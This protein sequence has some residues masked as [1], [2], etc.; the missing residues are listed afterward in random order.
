[1][2]GQRRVDRRAWMRGVG[3]WIGM[4]IAAAA[5]RAARADASAAGAA[6][7]ALL[8]AADEEDL[9]LVPQNALGRGDLRHAG[10]FGDLITDGWREAVAAASRRQRARLDRIDRASLGDAD[11]IARDVFAWQLDTTLRAH[12]DGVA[13][14]QQQMP[15]DHLFGP[16]VVFAQLSAG[17]GVAP[18]ETVAHFEQGLQRLGGYAVWLDRAI[19]QMR[20]GITQGH[21][22]PAIVTERLIAQ[23]R[24]TLEAGV[25]GSPF[26]RPLAR[27]HGRAGRDVQARLASR[28]EAV[29]RRRI[30]PASARMLEFLEREYL[31]ARGDGPPGLAGMRDGALVYRHALQTH[32][33]LALS[34]EQI[35]RL[36]LDEVARIEGERDAL[37][38]RLGFAGS[39]AA[40]S[41]RV[42][43]DPALAYA[44]AD[45]LLQRHRDAVA[46]I[47][48][49]LPRWF[50]RLPRAPLDVRLVPPEQQETAGGAYYVIGTADG[51]RPGVFYVNPHDLPNQVACRVLALTLHEAVPGHHLQG[52][53][54]LEDPTLPALLRHGY[55]TAYGEG[56]ALYAESLGHEMGLY[57]DAVQDWGRS[58]LELFRAL[59]LVVDTGLHARGWSR[60]QALRYL[61]EH[62]SLPGSYLEQEVDRYIAW[63]GQATAYKVGEVALQRL[64]RDAHRARG[65]RWDVRE[66]HEQVLGT[67]A[68]P[69]AVLERKVGAWAAS[70]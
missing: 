6:L 9:R 70:T 14:I 36:G 52:S 10:E 43:A 28:Y 29:V 32:T 50:S 51:S 18:Y 34:A 12:A 49:L 20:R 65:G 39:A 60:Q 54:A 26:L 67:G 40:F 35:H 8:A 25:A 56:W 37:R 46:R 1:M 30:L 15:L 63:P 31:A 27:L 7:A 11:R 61:A 69:L 58:D 55:N 24:A 41:A 17:D 22:Q 64:R 21:V 3:G 44:S 19:G 59:R 23:F 5:S 66:F 16:H 68:I 4:P 13:R 42:A 45:D 57:E 33:T 48:P 53:L 47:R 62:S 38:S 2:E